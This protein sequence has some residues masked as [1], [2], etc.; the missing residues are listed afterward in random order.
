M[1]QVETDEIYVGVNK[2]GMQFVIPVQAKGKTDE[3]GVVQIEQDFAICKEKFPDLICRSIA[4]QFIKENL[5]ALFEFETEKGDVKIREEKHYQL[6]QNT[7]LD[8]SEINAR[9][10]E[11]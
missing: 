7:E 9:V 5:I 2:K 10:V 8:I 11:K 4:A 1:G 6:V 3:I